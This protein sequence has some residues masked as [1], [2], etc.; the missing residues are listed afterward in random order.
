VTSLSLAHEENLAIITTPD[1]IEKISIS[2]M[3]P[4]EKDNQHMA[5]SSSV[6]RKSV[7]KSSIKQTHVIPDVAQ[8]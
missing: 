4:K 8:F 1:Y 5:K 6:K 2:V 3:T 7:L